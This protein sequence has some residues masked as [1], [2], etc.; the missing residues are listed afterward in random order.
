MQIKLSCQYAFYLYVST[1]SI[2]WSIGKTL[3]PLFNFFFSE[4]CL[5][6]WEK[7]SLFFSSSFIHPSHKV[8][9]VKLRSDSHS[10]AGA[11]DAAVVK[12]QKIKQVHL[13]DKGVSWIIE[14]PTLIKSV[15]KEPSDHIKLASLFQSLSSS[16]AMQDIVF[17]KA[18]AILT[19]SFSSP[20]SGSGL[21]K[22]QRGNYVYSLWATYAVLIK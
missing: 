1:H 2:C 9:A 13:K 15:W 21:F 7:I 17:T 19:H 22:V 10:L 18:L 8:T 14:S 4:F 6:D 11:G 5:V 20:I 3:I 16:C 12:T